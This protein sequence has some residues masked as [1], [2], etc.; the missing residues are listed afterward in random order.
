MAAQRFAFAFAPRTRRLL[1]LGGFRPATC[2]VVLDDERFAARFGRFRAVTPVTNL[3]DACITRGYRAI[4]ALGPRGS[5]A[6]RGATFGTTTE[7]G[8]CV[9]FHQPI[10]I[11]AGQRMLHPG[12]TVTVAEPEAL[13]EAVL[14]A[15]AAQGGHHQPDVT[16]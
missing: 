6:D 10:A 9:R 12:L 7:A 13:L 2:E 4:K 5:F 1:A 16:G 14:T 8:V 11:L 15:I 3:R